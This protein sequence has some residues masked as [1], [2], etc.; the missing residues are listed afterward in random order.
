MA[1]L[2]AGRCFGPFEP[3]GTSYDCLQRSACRKEACLARACTD[4]ANLPRKRGR[5][6]YS[7]DA[8][9]CSSAVVR[10]RQCALTVYASPPLSD[11]CGECRQARGEA[12]GCAWAQGSGR[13]REAGRWPHAA[14]RSPTPLETP[15]HLKPYRMAVSA[16]VCHGSM[17]FALPPPRLGLMQVHCADE[18]S[19]P[20][21][22]RHQLAEKYRGPRGW[23]TKQGWTKTLFLK[24]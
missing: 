20:G 18:V 24:F 2:S 4:K 23:V 22:A 1:C 8:E 14:V 6:C 19:L 17:S 15:H 11:T 10:T 7:D 9:H 3:P 21:A 12:G 13:H 5:K 16:S